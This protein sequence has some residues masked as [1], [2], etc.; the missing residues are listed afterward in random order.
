VATAF[1]EA[2]AEARDR[3]SAVD[4]GPTVRPHLDRALDVVAEQV[5]RT[6]ETLRSLGTALTTA[7][8][9]GDR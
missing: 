2:T 1:P 6:D 8:R 4:W 9:S 5:L 7:R 3:A